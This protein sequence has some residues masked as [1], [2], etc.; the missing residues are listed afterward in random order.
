MPTALQTI[1]N[2]NTT[3][4][5]NVGCTIE[6]NMNSMIDGITVT[7]ASDDTVYTAGIT[8]WPNNKAN[9]FK[10][11]FPVDSIVKSFR[12]VYPGAKYYINSTADVQTGDYLPFRTISYTGEGQNINVTGAK[13]RIYYPGITTS[14]K[15]WVS[16]LNGNVDLTVQYLQTSGTWSAANKTGSIPT[17][18]KMAL[19]N[20]IVLKFEK[21]H[22][23]PSGYTISIT[24]SDN[25]VTTITVNTMSS[26]NSGSVI[27]YLTNSTW[28]CV[29]GITGIPDSVSLGSPIYIK[30]I[31]VTAINPGG[32][33][34]VIEIS[35]RYLK[36]ISSDIS[37][38]DITKDSSS[39]AT[40]I[41][42][43]GTVT[44]NTFNLNLSKYNQTV[45]PIIEYNRSLPWTSSITLENEIYLIKNAELKPY[46]K[47]Y[48]SAG[49][50]GTAPNKY[51]KSPQGIYFIDTFNISE[52]GDANISALDGAKYLMDTFCP[53]L[54]CDNFPVTAILRNLL[55]SIGFTSYNFNLAET[56]TSIPQMRY[57]WTLDSNTV[58]Q[59]IQELCRD[60]QMNAIFD[61]NGILQFY[62]RDYIYS[63]SRSIDNNFY[64]DAEG[65]ILPN[66]VSLT[67]KEI[68][69][70]NMVKVLWQS[71]VVSTYTGTSNFLWESPTTYLSAGA[72]KNRPDRS[73]GPAINDTDNDFFVIDIPEIEVNDA[74]TSFYNFAG[75]ILIDSEI[76]QFDAMGYDYTPIDSVFSQEVWIESSTDIWKYRSLADA[77]V[78]SFKPNG[79]YRI[80]QQSGRGAL[81]TTVATHFCSTEKLNGW[82]GLLANATVSS[83]V[84]YNTDGN[85]PFLDFSSQIFVLD[86]PSTTSLRV[87]VPTRDY[88]YHVSIQRTLSGNNYGNPV[89]LTTT[90]API[91][92]SNLTAGAT[93]DITVYQS[94]GTDTGNSQTIKN[95]TLNASSFSGSIV[96]NSIDPKIDIKYANSYLQVTNRSTN[97]K[98]FSLAYKSFESI[99]L[100]T[101]SS[102]AYS[103]LPEAWRYLASTYS[104]SYY[105]FGTNIFM[106]SSVEEPTQSG[107]LGFFIDN[108]G[109]N[110]YY[111]VVE[112]TYSA[113]ASDRKS[114]RI[115][116][117]TAKNPP[118]VLYDSQITT[119]STFD[120]IYGGKA[121]AIDVKVKVSADSIYIKAYINGFKI[122]A[123]DTNNNSNS[124]YNLIL[125]P[126]KNVGVATFK[127][128]CSFDY[129]Y[130]MTIDEPKYK[131]SDNDGN[132]YVGQFAN[133]TLDTA[134]GN[135]FY[136]ANNADSESNKF[137]NSIEEFG[138]VVR[139]IA[140]V[141]TKFNSRPALPIKW[142]TGINEY[143]KIIGQK[144]SSFGGESYVLNNTSTTIPLS[145]G[146]SASFYV[147]GNDIGQSGQLEYSTEQPDEYNYKEPVT[148]AAT[149]LQ[150]ETDVEKLAKWIKDRAVNRSRIVDMN[151]F[152]NP[153]LEVG[154]II[155]IK[156][157]HQNLAGTEKFIITKVSHTYNQGLGTSVSCRTL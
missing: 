121:Y 45:S 148:F 143:A 2:N 111:V 27:C 71:P 78:D 76:I 120:G 1:F 147:V 88:T 150:N 65:S 6:Y 113:A 46:I 149:W 132:L 112:N 17:G 119:Q 118:H 5:T 55:D 129:V 86:E 16:P 155:S 99:I 54:L 50:L 146:N 63:T 135:L 4:K 33:I 43:V 101:K 80:K 91:L 136:N 11:L 156:Y 35:A 153:T 131:S 10:K 144:I 13:P 114:I 77:K 106:N 64:Y 100:P 74:Q 126:T 66:I 70:A 109:K 8:N 151:I 84:I 85:Y 53:D 124:K 104:D 140:Y 20:K 122:T 139:E 75:Y 29:D 127:G 79:K 58:W 89:I 157:P 142:S 56:E 26:T 82:T 138:S 24:K 61:N 117:T 28:T 95:Y 48:D 154:N 23:L 12:P 68:A 18:N 141:K 59:A 31:N 19:A 42:P 51:Y 125:D 9:P 30:A 69:S 103:Y 137:K 38:F 39:S 25:S 41:L 60:I 133:A 96:S 110:G 14:Y 72:L 67:Q 3:V 57:W 105:A 98:Q 22:T 97:Q 62:S 123:I 21:F 40:D 134:Y 15:Y 36:D 102:I 87:E 116:K 32:Y 81:G 49:N 44:A 145:D 83:S 90:E 108:S 94:Y 73:D 115:I 107:G 37:D 128:K 92:I 152:G 130:G 7:S 47:I 34:G 52:Y 93:Y